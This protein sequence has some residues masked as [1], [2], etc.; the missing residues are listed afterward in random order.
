MGEATRAATKSHG[1]RHTAHVKRLRAAEEWRIQFA[2]RDLQAQTKSLNDNAASS[3]RTALLASASHYAGLFTQ[4]YSAVNAASADYTDLLHMKDRA[5]IGG[6]LFEITLT[7]LMLA[8]P[9]LGAIKEA[10]KATVEVVKG[11]AE[12]SKA[13]GKVFDASK[14][15]D[16]NAGAKLRISAAR[17][18][19]S[20]LDK[21]SQNIQGVFAEAMGVIDTW[22]F[23]PRGDLLHQV[24]QKLRK[25]KLKFEVPDRVHDPTNLFTDFFLYDMAAAYVRA[26]VSL[27]YTNNSLSFPGG[28]ATHLKPEDHYFDG[29]EGKYVWVEG[30]S[31]EACKTIY[32][33]LG[34]KSPHAHELYRTHRMP[35]SRPGDLV[36]VWGAGF[37]RNYS[38]EVLAPAGSWVNQTEDEWARRHATQH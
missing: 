23:N 20:D 38:R 31:Q 29:A 37:Y 14:P 32:E 36:T 18:F 7:A 33:L 12:L 24:H 26:C 25:V 2:L 10:I 28:D 5:E 30:L 8:V 6:A 17:T 11:A 13:I 21:A 3:A 35:V 19:F 16:P 27:N 22:Q 9:E 4:L 34:R 15:D 1:H